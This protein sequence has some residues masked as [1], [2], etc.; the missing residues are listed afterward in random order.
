MMYDGGYYGFEL[1]EYRAAGISFYVTRYCKPKTFHRSFSADLI[2]L[3]ESLDV[4]EA[5]ERSIFRW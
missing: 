4:R 5:K 3:Y 1:N 2:K